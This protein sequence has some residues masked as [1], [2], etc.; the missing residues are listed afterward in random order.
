MLPAKRLGDD[1]DEPAPGVL[2]WLVSCDE[3]GVH[4]SPCYGFG[5]LWMTWQ[6][7]GDLARLIRD[8]RTEHRYRD[9]IKWNH[10]R[11][12]SVPFYQALVES[13]FKASWLGFHC[14][15]VRK[16]IVRPELHGGSWD[17]ARQKHFGMLL[18]K[19][20][21]GCIQTHLPREQ[22]I[23]VYLDP[24]HSSYKKASEVL[25]KITRSVVQRSYPNVQIEGAF[26]RDSKET[27][28]IQLCDLLLGAVMSD[29]DRNPAG[30]AKAELRAF[31]AGHL[32]WTDL[33]ADT[34]PDERKFNI[35]MFYDT[36]RGPR[37]ST[38]RPVLLTYPL[39]ERR[40]K[41]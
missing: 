36:E 10:V 31:I 27:P 4:G 34:H 37:Q 41:R 40:R 18:R 19:K 13:F 2:R 24:L 16:A 5:T 8:L 21:L 25:E 3:S 35:W 33:H 11:R 23:R 17:E 9:E 6:R 1:E 20:V 7:R 12:A 15:V 22:T 28:T 38:T 32:G 26:E 14:L 30:G 29:W 39:P